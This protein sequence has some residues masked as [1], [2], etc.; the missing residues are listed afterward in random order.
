MNF[1]MKGTYT[2]GKADGENRNKM[3]LASAMKK[4]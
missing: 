2:S 4:S 1:E 3:I